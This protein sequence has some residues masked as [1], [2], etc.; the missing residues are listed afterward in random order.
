M[1][2]VPREHSRDH[3]RE[4]V[5]PPCIPGHI[6]QGVPLIPT[7]VYYTHPRVYLSYPPGCTLGSQNPRVYLRLSEPTGVLY[8]AGYPR[9]YY[10]QQDTHGVYS[11]SQD[12]RCV[13][14]LS[15]PTG[16]PRCGI[17]TG[18]PRCGIPTG[19]P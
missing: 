1:L 17:P 7:R 12:P 14:Y 11:T 6:Y 8:P 10:T 19:V 9:V 3:G 13:Q 4:A 15:G 5:Y 18:V 16:V 2:G